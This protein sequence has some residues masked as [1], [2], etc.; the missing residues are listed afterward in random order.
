MLCTIIW[1]GGKQDYWII[2]TMWM[3]FVVEWNYFYEEL[4][5]YQLVVREEWNEFL[6]PFDLLL[7]RYYPNSYTA[8]Q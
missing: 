7:Q 3:W 6:I 2:G 1:Y 5:E 8:L 4:E